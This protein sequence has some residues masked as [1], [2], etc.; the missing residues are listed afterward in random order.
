[1]KIVLNAREQKMLLEN[2]QNPQQALNLMHFILTARVVD[3]FGDSADLKRHLTDLMWDMTHCFDSMPMARKG[4]QER[5]D[6][7]N[8]L[9]KMFD[10]VESK[11]EIEM[12]LPKSSPEADQVIIDA[13]DRITAKVVLKFSLRWFDAPQG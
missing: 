1:M 6:V 10:V 11:P 7:A 12:R 9:R 3:H 2:C 5:A 13:L 8:V 4:V